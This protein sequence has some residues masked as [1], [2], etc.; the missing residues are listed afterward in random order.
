MSK[1]TNQNRA[2]DICRTVDMGAIYEL[3]FV[4]GWNKPAAAYRLTKAQAAVVD[5]KDRTF[6]RVIVRETGKVIETRKFKR[7]WKPV[8]SAQP[9]GAVTWG[10][11][12]YRHS[13]GSLSNDTFNTEYYKFVYHM[14]HNLNNNQI[15]ITAML[16][17]GKTQEQVLNCYISYTESNWN[18]LMG[19][20]SYFKTIPYPS[21][22]L[23]YRFAEKLDEIFNT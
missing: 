1:M 7:E 10:K 21:Y 3:S 5:Y 22:G 6:A 2:T 14:S 19:L 8:K 18:I 12:D 20:F 9:R 15:K 13:T 4:Y 16:N 17:D 23:P 11:H